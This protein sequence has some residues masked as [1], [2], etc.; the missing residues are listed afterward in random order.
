MFLGRNLQFLRR[1]RAMTQEQLAQ[2]MGVSRQ[3]VSKWESGQIPDLEKLLEL[4]DLFHCKLDDLLRQ[5][6]SL[7]E[8]PIRIL[9]L[10][11]FSMAQYTMISPNA[12]ADLHTYLHTWA[13]QNGLTQQ[14][15]LS[16][17]F[18][19]APQELKT[20]FH[21]TAFSAALV[22]PEDFT[23]LT[24]GPTLLSQPDCSYAVLTLPEPAGRDANLISRGIRSILE[25]LQ[26]SG[27]PKSAREGC[28]PCFEHRFEKNG[29]PFVDIYLQCQPTNDTETLSLI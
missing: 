24:D 2:R 23:P 7:Q 20:R 26:E 25:H 13:R 10:R 21:L 29:L 1:R 3:A 17:S 5:D 14:P 15:Y 19:Y 18:P 27:I 16:W 22:L 12:E 11:G 9:R 4:A 28:L 8:S 6:L